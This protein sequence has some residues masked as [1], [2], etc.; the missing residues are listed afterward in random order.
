MPVL[1]VRRGEQQDHG[2]ELLFA[3]GCLEGGDLAVG[4]ERCVDGHLQGEVQ[5]VALAARPAPRLQVGNF[6][7]GD[8]CT[9][10]VGLGRGPGV[11]AVVSVS[12]YP[13]HLAAE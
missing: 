6:G 13:A 4:D 8:A 5:G 1:E 10:E 12:R 11:L 7:L 2:D 9:A 3:V